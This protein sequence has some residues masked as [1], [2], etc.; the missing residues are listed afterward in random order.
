MTITPSLT[1]KKTKKW[2]SC[3]VVVPEFKPRLPISGIFQW[4]WLKLRIPPNRPVLGSPPIPLPS[5][6]PVFTW[7]PIILSKLI[8]H[9]R[10]DQDSIQAHSCPPQDNQPGEVI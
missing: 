8:D 9:Q 10:W 4:D 3:S 5:S 2:R 1:K 6:C 7:A